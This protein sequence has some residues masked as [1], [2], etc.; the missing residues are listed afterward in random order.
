MKR[1]ILLLSIAITLQ[2]SAQTDAENLKKIYDNSLTNGMSYQWL[3]HLSN[4]IGG[5]L[6]GSLN[7]ERA[8]EYTKEEFEKLGLDM[9]SQFTINKVN[10]NDKKVT[11]MTTKNNTSFEFTVKIRI[12][13]AME[14]NYFTND[15]ILNYVLKNIANS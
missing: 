15:G 4:Q 5:R 6:S 8:V 2:I 3:D 1:I 14:W 7:A 11:I 12:D 13:T 9:T 10:V